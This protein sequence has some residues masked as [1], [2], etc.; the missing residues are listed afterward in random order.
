[1]AKSNASSSS[2]YGGNT[3]M[4]FAVADSAEHPISLYAATKKSNEQD[5]DFIE[6]IKF[7]NNTKIAFQRMIKNWYF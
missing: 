7:K 4:P 2:V 5:P 3:K 6:K 1:M